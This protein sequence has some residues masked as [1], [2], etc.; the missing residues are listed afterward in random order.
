MWH[1]CVASNPEGCGNRR[2]LLGMFAVSVRRTEIA[3]GHGYGLPG[4][5]SVAWKVDPHMLSLKT[6]P[7]HDEVY[8]VF[9]SCVQTA[10][11]RLPTS[12]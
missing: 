1:R 3:A 5:G 6:A 2:R 4:Q 8:S 11:L 10:I 7:V 9:M 12:C